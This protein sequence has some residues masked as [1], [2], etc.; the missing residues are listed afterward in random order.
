MKKTPKSQRAFT[1]VE[2][3]AVLVIIGILAVIT[4]GIYGS[5]KGK[6]VESRL[7]AE[8]AAIELALEDYKAKTGQ[9]PYSDAWQYQYPPANWA[10]VPVAPVGNNLYRDLVAAPLKEGKPVFLPDVSED[11]HSADSLL[12]PVND[13][14]GGAPYV[15]WYYNSNNPKYNKNGYDLWVEYGD[16]GDKLDDPSDD[17][18]KTISNWQN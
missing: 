15:K 11:M 5:V 12:A 16:L 13:V 1:L 8:L 6:A 10:P 14:R 9:Y 7:E 17:T 4:M 18:V 2:I 3:L